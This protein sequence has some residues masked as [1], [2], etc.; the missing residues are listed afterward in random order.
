MRRDKTPLER[1]QHSNKPNT[2]EYNFIKKIEMMQR[3]NPRIGEE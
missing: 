3:K 2:E 1:Y